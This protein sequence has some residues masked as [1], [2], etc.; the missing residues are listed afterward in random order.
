MVAP[1]VER[2][3]FIHK[4]AVSGIPTVM[5]FTKEFARDERDDLRASGT[6]FTAA[7]SP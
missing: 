4:D 6:A 2:S 7:G 3:I 5:D 1:A